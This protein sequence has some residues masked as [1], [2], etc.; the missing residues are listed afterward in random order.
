MSHQ[1]VTNLGDS[2]PS[3]VTHC[4]LVY[5]SGENLWRSVWKC[6][7]D[8]LS[9]EHNVDEVTLEM[10]SHLAEDLFPD[11]LVFLKNKALSSVLASD[12]REGRHSSRITDGLQEIMS[13]IKILHA[14]LEHS[15]KAED[16]K[17]TSRKTKTTGRIP[18]N[19]ISSVVKIMHLWLIFQLWALKG[20]IKRN[21]F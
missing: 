15:G 12:G 5:V 9:R 20:F 7:M 13:F 18:L 19:S 8:V 17:Y 2:T 4:S 11:T 21:R 6:Q 3:V 1:E 10:W 16:L 14:L